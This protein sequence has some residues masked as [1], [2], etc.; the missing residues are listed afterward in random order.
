MSPFP[1]DVV[2][3]LIFMGFPTSTA[4]DSR[5]GGWLRISFRQ[6]M[7]IGFALLVLL[8]GSVAVQSWVL[9]ERLVG[10]SRSNSELA[11][12]LTG[13]VQALAERT[14][15]LERSARQSLVLD[16][17]EFRLR[18]AEHLAA[19]RHL[20]SEIE[21][22]QVRP[23][24][25]L[26]DAWR[27]VAVAL[28]K[29]VTQGASQNELQALIARLG[30]LNERIARGSR[31]WI[32]QGNARLLAELDQRRLQLGGQMALTL[33]A[34]LA[35]AVAMGWWLV[36]PVRQLDRAIAELGRGR[37]SGQIR[38]DGPDDLQRLGRRLEWLRAH[39]AELETDRER[40]LRHVSHEL[41]TPLTALKEGI[42]LISEEVPGPLLAGQREIVDILTHNVAALQLQIESLLRLN[43]VAS[44]ARQLNPQRVSLRRLFSDA[45]AR[46]ELQCQ[47]RGVT[48]DLTAPDS[49][50]VLDAE[51]LSVILDNLLSNAIDFSPGGGQVTL[52]V[53]RSEGRWRI[54]CIDQGPGVA[55][56]DVERIFE[57]FVQGSRAAPVKRQGSGVGL[58][59]VRELTRALGGSV[60]LLPSAVG[61]H[62]RVELPDE[63]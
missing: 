37:F 8:L 61:A 16:T 17:P 45:V 2:I 62:F 42:A 30:E 63:N 21:A 40:A 32:D 59:I 5:A 6:G 1:D 27:R 49:D 7:V 23:L 35:V 51:K 31:Q 26:L 52:R 34:A 41:K 20:V 29:G 4:A 43:A 10:Q 25:P 36:R 47:A 38:V 55:D 9:L 44:E 22:H 3:A 13:E 11:L 50:A 14:V 18:F 28:E 60:R 57:P 56:S 54:D 24:S 48:V 33:A 58:S 53:Q 39:L 46:R 12:A 19:V 15:D